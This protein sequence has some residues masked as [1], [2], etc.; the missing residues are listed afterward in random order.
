M[1]GNMGVGFMLD[2]AE[3]FK[4]GIDIDFNQLNVVPY[5]QHVGMGPI[6]IPS[7]PSV[8]PPQPGPTAYAMYSL[9]L[10]SV[11]TKYTVEAPQF[12]ISIVDWL[13]DYIDGNSDWYDV[14]P[15][16][17]EDWSSTPNILADPHTSIV[18]NTKIDPLKAW[19][20]DQLIW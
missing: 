13:M 7:D 2:F 5:R 20:G 9:N 6:P 15:H 11:S 8:P 12:S 3:L 4:F 18:V 1:R 14:F 10:G 19:T 16:D 17:Y